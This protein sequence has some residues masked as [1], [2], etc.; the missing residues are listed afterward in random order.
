M[1]DMRRAE[2]ELLVD[3]SFF[4]QLVDKI[5]NV[6]HV[7][8]LPKK[9]RATNE[10]SSYRYEAVVHIRVE[11]ECPRTIHQIHE[12]AWINFQPEK[13]NRKSLTELLK[14][15]VSTSTVV[16]VG[17]IPPSKS[18]HMSHVVTLLSDQVN[19]QDDFAWLSAPHNDA[20]MSAVDLVDV[21]R[22]AG[23][24]VDLSWA[25]S[26]G[27]WTPSSTTKN[28]VHKPLCNNPLQRQI[29]PELNRS[30]K[31]QLPSYVIP[32]TITILD[33]IPL[34][35]NGKID[36]RAL[37]A[38]IPSRAQGR[39]ADEQPVSEAEGHIRD[40][41]GEVLDVEPAKI[42]LGDSFFQIGGDSI[43]AM[44]LVGRARKA[45]VTLTVRRL[46]Q[47]PKLQDLPAD[48][49]STTPLLDP[50]RESTSYT[51][52]PTTPL[53]NAQDEA[54]QQY[55]RPKLQILLLCYA[56][57]MEPIAFFSIFPY[58]AQMTQHN[59]NLPESD[60]GFYSG[61]FES[62]FSGVQ[63]LTLFYW[64]SMA[65]RVG[66]K[67]MLIWSLLG[68]TVG[69]LLFGFSTNLWQMGLVRC[70]TGMV[71]GGNVIIRAMIGERCTNETRTQAFSW[72]CFAG[73]IALFVGPLIG[74]ALASPVIQY[75]AIF[76]G[77][78]FFERY[79]FSLPGI[80]VAFLSATCAIV[81]ALFVDEAVEEE[82]SASDTEP[83]A[84]SPAL[85]WASIRDLI[86]APGVGRMLCSFLHVQFVGSAFMAVNTLTLY[87]G[88]SRGGLGFSEHEI[89]VYMTAQGGAEAVWMLLAFPPLHRRIGTR[90]MVLLGSVA[91]PLFF[92]GYIVMNAFLRDASSTSFLVY[93][94][95]LAAMTFIGPAIFLS[96][97]AVQLGLQ[98]VSPSLRTLGTLNAIAESAYCLIKAVV[99]AVSTTI[100][101][102]G[103]PYSTRVPAGERAFINAHR[104]SYA[105][106][107]RPHSQWVQLTLHSWHI[108]QPKR[109]GGDEDDDA[110][111]YKLGRTTVIGFTRD[112]CIVKVLKEDDYALC[113]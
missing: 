110:G 23:Y 51:Q 27:A 72:Y 29:E 111:Q 10:L 77:I 49:D 86:Q 9:M 13:L 84:S 2:A 35:D 109:E 48:M 112:L 1:E 4:T 85:S 113:P 6:E 73:N 56:R 82:G 98:E 64:G 68:T 99:P 88:V 52:L 93:R 21:A 105:T 16:A 62:L 42:G 30:L 33:K 12:F 3:P 8:I 74:G 67:T 94:L 37:E 70:F 39:T 22:E 54:E 78:A 20:S 43:A 81:I 96:M 17:N 79:P 53:L 101:A 7:E 63:T 59:G 24:R 66:G 92:A 89:A 69:T 104:H 83:T 18:G 100:F 80:A 55:S 108:A 45:G 91:F 46:L 103:V 47:H 87:T 36:R 11:D 38:S 107:Q 90:G 26:A 58:I 34:N 5:E 25:P 19:S 28:G 15:K 75:P 106:S 65:D 41:W 32:S 95:V 57:L 14:S 76:K 31:A 60:I 102:I 44:K 50:D 40:M 61:L 71:A 97:T